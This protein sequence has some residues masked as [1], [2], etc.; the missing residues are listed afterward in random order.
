MGAMQR[1]YFIRGLPD[2]TQSEAVAEDRGHALMIQ[3]TYAHTN[4]F[5]SNVRL[6]VR[7]SNLPQAQLTPGKPS[8]QLPAREFSK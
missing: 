8:R 6:R 2:G 5:I 7:V 4:G 3:G 1:G